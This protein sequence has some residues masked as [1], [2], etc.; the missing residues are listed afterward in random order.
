[1]DLTP[2]Q[3][4]LPELQDAN[5]DAS[6]L[7][8]LFDD[9]AACAELHEVLVRNNPRALSGQGPAYTLEEARDA[10]LSGEIRA[11]QLR[12][13]FEGVQWWDTISALPKGFHLIRIQHTF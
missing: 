6:V 5:I 2:P 1:M 7:A 4:D 9:V 11:V 12:Y 3:D 8:Q 10:M 13:S